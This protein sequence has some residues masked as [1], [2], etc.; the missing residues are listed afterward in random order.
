MTSPSLM[1]GSNGIAASVLHAGLL[2]A[3]FSIDLSHPPSSLSWVPPGLSQAT[4]AG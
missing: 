4:E 3:H 2:R 1:G